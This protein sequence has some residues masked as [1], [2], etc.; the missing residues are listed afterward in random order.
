MS[1]SQQVKLPNVID[2]DTVKG[3][4]NYECIPNGKNIKSDLI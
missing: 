4:K 3:T 2:L 1:L